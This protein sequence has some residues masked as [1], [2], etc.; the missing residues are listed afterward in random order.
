MACTLFNAQNGYKIVFIKKNGIKRKCNN[1][2][3]KKTW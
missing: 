3:Y 2:K 1:N